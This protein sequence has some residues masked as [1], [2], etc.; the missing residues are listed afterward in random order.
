[1]FRTVVRTSAITLTGILVALLTAWGALALY[2]SGPAGFN[3]V[4]AAGYGL[5]GLTTLLSFA[6]VRW[7]RRIT[8]AFIVVFAVL[9]IWWNPIEPSNDRNWQPDVA[10]LPYATENGDLITV[11]NIRNFDYRTETEYI[12]AYYDKTFDVR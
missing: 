3:V 6:T 12:S 7:R 1:M 9:V 8:G 11:H 10:V 4:L 2:Y 5:C